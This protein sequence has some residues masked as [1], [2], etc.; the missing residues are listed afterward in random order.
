[1]KSVALF[2]APFVAAVTVQLQQLLSEKTQNLPLFGAKVQIS[3][4]TFLGVLGIYVI[5][6]T[7]LLSNYTVEI[8][9]GNDKLAKKMT[10]AK[11]LPTATTVYTIGL[12]L[13]GQ[14]LTFLLK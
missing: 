8:K 4:P 5:M 12:I 2:F 14:M 13:G 11:A 9:I 7:I 6:I 3:S 10:I 1:M